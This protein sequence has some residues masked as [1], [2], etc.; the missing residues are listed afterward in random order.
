MLSILAIAIACG[1]TSSEDYSNEPQLNIQLVQATNSSRSKFAY[2]SE[3][4][5]NNPLPFIITSDPDREDQKDANQI[6]IMLQDV[7]GEIIKTVDL[8]LKR[9]EV[10]PYALKEESRKITISDF[11]NGI[12][13]I[14]VEL[15]MDFKSKVE[16]REETMFYRGVV[17]NVS[18]V[19]GEVSIN[20]SSIEVINIPMSIYIDPDSNAYGIQGYLDFSSIPN[21]IDV[22]SINITEAL[23]PKTELT[24]LAQTEDSST[25]NDSYS[26]RS[27][28][29]NEDTNKPF[30]QF[31]E[32]FGIDKRDNLFL[33]KGESGMP[34]R[35]FLRGIMGHMDNDSPE[36]LHGEAFFFNFDTSYATVIAQ[37]YSKFILS[38][39]TNH[40]AT[41][42][43]TYN[44]TLNHIKPRIDNIIT[45]S[46]NTHDKSIISV[47]TTDLYF[48]EV[49]YK[50]ARILRNIDR[51]K[52]ISNAESMNTRLMSVSNYTGI[53][54]FLFPEG[55]EHRTLKVTGSA[56]GNLL[57]INQAIGTD[58]VVD[59][60]GGGNISGANTSLHFIFNVEIIPQY[61]NDVIKEY[62][63]THA[64]L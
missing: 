31:F 3:Y 21:V 25:I 28:V 16:S 42:F 49:S 48:I 24:T 55:R 33:V 59:S 45:T 7:S 13:N 44:R 1:N 26:G 19:D 32:V 10:A 36:A 39:S 27:V 12:Y 61:N 23:V 4:V 54:Y 2:E 6:R 51:I 20:G 60:T 14:I 58:S 5:Q 17:E 11:P 34:E 57:T 22:E 40:Y 41:I 50:L 63:D 38:Q 64:P 53:N 35:F 43:E 18:V 62:Y 9:E 52:G 47:S 29:I 15:G 46:A 30:S 8:K 56:S 37:W